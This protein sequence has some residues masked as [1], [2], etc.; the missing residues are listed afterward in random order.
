MRFKNKKV[1]FYI[2]FLLLTFSSWSQNTAPKLT[3]TGHQAYCPQTEIRIV[4]DFN[5]T[6]PDDTG[7]EALYIQISTGYKQGEDVLALIE[8][9]PN[10]TS[11]WNTNEGK[12]TLSGKNTTQVS[13]IDLVAATKAVVFES[14]SD[15]PSDKV[16]SITIGDVNYLPSTGHYYEYVPKTGITW[17]A[18][19]TEAENRTYY[20]LKGYLATITSAAEAQLTGEQAAGAGWI[21]GSD[22][23]TE[24][25]WKWVTG[26]EAGTIFWNGGINGTTPNYANWNANE[27]NQAGN[28]DYT[29]I[30]APNI[31]TP[32]SWNDLSNTGNNTGDYQPK[33]YVVEYGGLPGDPVLNISASSSIY[34]TS[35]SNTIPGQI[36]GKGTVTIEATVPFG[37]VLWF[38]AITGG[39]IIGKKQQLKTPII[40]TTTTYYALA[41]LN[42][43]TMGK[44]IPVTVTVVSLPK[45]KE[46]ILFKN[47][48]EDG[49]AD[50]FTD[51][52]LTEINSIITNNNTTGVVVTYY[53]SLL[54]AKQGNKPLN[55]IYN[56]Q[57]GA[58]IYARVE[59]TASCYQISTI[60]LQVS[61]T[62][63]PKG[64]V[65]E[66]EVCDD[67]ISDGFNTFDLTLASKIFINQ[68]PSGQNLSVHYF[69]NL[70]DAQLE[71]HEIIQQK[72]YIN[73]TPFSQ[74]LYVRVENNDNGECFGIGNHLLLTVHS[75]PEFLVDN[76]DIYCMDNKA[77]TL[78]IFNPKGNYTYKWQDY[79]GKIV[80][81][82][83]YAEVFSGGV[84][85]VIATSPFGCE[86]FPVSVTVTESE[87]ATIDF[88][89]ISIVQT[90]DNNSILIN[91]TNNNLGKGDYE[92]ALDDFNGIYTDNPFFENVSAGNHVVFVKDKKGCGFVS[93]DVFILGFPKFFT[94]NNDGIN[95]V[96]QINGLGP[97]YSDA[98]KVSIY[99]RYGK[100]IKQMPAKNAI[101]DGTFNGQYLPSTD[102]WFIAELVLTSSGNVK[103][104]KGHFSLVR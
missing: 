29:H 18:A 85:T 28:E 19:K 80:S 56:N 93:L 20:G 46:T 30:T 43:C 16:F 51:F 78:N 5:I 81:T 26:P 68:F 39:N 47:C 70:T 94:P 84:Y 58:R 2:T 38:D 103:I 23:A 21:G 74:K 34:T 45:I 37:D 12:L 31:G 25:V 88:N 10:I 97:N 11:S 24:G 40:N 76:T 49:I 14:T 52:N 13:Y 27:P 59:N 87:S 104:Y 48:D 1:I 35:I 102:Y 100:L 92:F 64:Y 6:D 73:K 4:T 55:S 65:H 90:L 63:F 71:Q 7:I 17:K 54:D 62:S 96:W 33:G 72:T 15:T 99:N 89:D 66:L 41:S 9:H 36:C 69:E 57:I 22:E 42:G 61:T 75:R 67:N 53:R 8:T 83:D 101:W 3:A 77:I 44:R 82:F 60:D 50:G 91:D 32:G 86:S 95:D 98:S 79:N